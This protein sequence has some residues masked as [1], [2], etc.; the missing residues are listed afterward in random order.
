M[1]V[2]VAVVVA[3]GVTVGVSVGAGVS[4]AV[5]LGVAV[6]VAVAVAVAVGVGEGVSV[7]VGVSVG[8]GV[9][10]GSGCKAEQ[11][12]SSISAAA[13]RMAAGRVEPMN[14]KRPDRVVGWV[15]K[16]VLLMSAHMRERD[17]SGL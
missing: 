8:T 9:A 15:D 1:D 6:G 10:V 16:W 17:N 14:R 3:V 13:A 5:G 7:A 4:V 2:T 11:P 12:V